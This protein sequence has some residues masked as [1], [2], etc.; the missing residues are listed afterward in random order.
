MNAWTCGQAA[1]ATAMFRKMLED[2]PCNA[3]NSRIKSVSLFN[4]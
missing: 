1:T 4:S 2:P 3:R